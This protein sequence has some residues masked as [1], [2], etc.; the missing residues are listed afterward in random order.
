[1]KHRK[2]PQ[3]RPTT[4]DLR[5]K[6]PQP[7]WET[8]WWLK[9]CY[10]VEVGSLSHYLRFLTGFIHPGGKLSP[11]VSHQQDR[12]ES[13]TKDSNPWL[14]VSYRPSL[15]IAWG[16]IGFLLSSSL[17]FPKFPK[18]WRNRLAWVFLLTNAKFFIIN[19]PVLGVFIL[20]SDQ[21]AHIRGEWKC[22]ISPSNLSRRSDSVPLKKDPN[23]QWWK[24]QVIGCIFGGLELQTTSFLWL[25][26][27]DD[28]KSL[29]KKWLFHHFHPL[30]NGLFRVPGG[31][32]FLPSQRWWIFFESANIFASIQRGFHD[33]PK[34]FEHC[35]RLGW[36]GR[37]WMISSTLS[38]GFCFV[39]L[40]IYFYPGSYSKPGG[41]YFPTMRSYAEPQNPQNPRVVV[42]HGELC[43]GL[44][45]WYFLAYYFFDLLF[46]VPFSSL[47]CWFVFCCLFLHSYS[48]QRVLTKNCLFVRNQA[49]GSPPSSD[50]SDSRRCRPPDKTCSKF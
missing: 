23:R 18:P 25:F 45:V 42:E 33:V 39:S 36:S 11:D 22:T 46:T 35:L 9:S 34:G 27:L 21:P 17:L 16:L 31:M 3:K 8:V 38:G 26:Q 28:S 6:T 47:I 44:F 24:P 10:P 40:Q 50:I 41:M 14:E 5:K 20:V 29:H 7:F 48:N 4:K 1:M 37:W 15:E 19:L 2:L 43:L 12:E 49:A 30:K 32:K 13:R